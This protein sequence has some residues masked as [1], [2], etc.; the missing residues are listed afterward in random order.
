MAYYSKNYNILQEAY[1]LIFTFIHWQKYKLILYYFKLVHPRTSLIENSTERYTVSFDQMAFLATA[2]LVLT[3]GIAASLRWRA[4]RRN[5]QYRQQSVD[6]LNRPRHARVS[7]ITMSKDEVRAR[8]GG[9][10]QDCR[11]QSPH[12]ERN[13]DRR[14]QNHRIRHLPK[15]ITDVFRKIKKPLR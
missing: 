14:I 5:Q 3:A 2:S 8:L 6:N 4:Y 15:C 12:N 1:G 7:L 9:Y 13:G 10:W 11:S